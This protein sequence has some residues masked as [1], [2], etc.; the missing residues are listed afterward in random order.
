MIP[1]ETKQC[2][3]CNAVMTKEESLHMDCGDDCLLCMAES[4]DPDCLEHAFRLQ[5]AEI[6]RLT[7]TADDLAQQLHNS[8]CIGNR[9]S[10]ENTR[11]TKERDAFYVGYRMK[12]D[13]ETKELRQQLAETIEV[14]NL[15]DGMYRSVVKQLAAKDSDIKAAWDTNRAIDKARMDD[16]A[17]YEALLAE[18]EGWQLVPKEPTPEMVSAGGWSG[19]GDLRASDRWVREEIYKRML[20]AAPKQGERK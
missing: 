11:L 4:G 12:C 17:K 3:I 19:N 16:R 15:A 5:K 9:L 14:A 7:K 6:E 18:R 20:A 1:L 8:I 10:E 13:V 2:R